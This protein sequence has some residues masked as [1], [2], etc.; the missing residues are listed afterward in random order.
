VRGPT[1]LLEALGVFAIAYC[2]VTHGVQAASLGLQRSKAER[3]FGL[4]NTRRTQ[5]LHIA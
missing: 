2:P 1:A 3:R 4:F 5:L